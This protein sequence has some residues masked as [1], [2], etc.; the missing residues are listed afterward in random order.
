AGVPAARW[1][2]EQAG[3]ALRAVG[4]PLSGRV[5]N[6]T[7]FPS[8]ERA[9]YQTPKSPAAPEAPT[10]ARRVV[11]VVKSRTKAS[12]QWFTSFA[13]R[14]PAELTKTTR[15][16]SAESAPAPAMLS[17]SPVAP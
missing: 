2:K 15:V 4:T 17:P 10:L 14:S 13:T 8:P 6:A 12:S 5:V 1:G 7:A 9:A 3:K 11:P 16:P